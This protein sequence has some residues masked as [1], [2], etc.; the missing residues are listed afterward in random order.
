MPS[1]A[2]KVCE[3][4]DDG[5]HVVILGDL[6]SGAPGKG[7]EPLFGEVGAVD[8]LS[9]FS[10]GYTHQPNSGKVLLKVGWPSPIFG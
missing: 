3:H 8:R 10:M 6:S 2:T 1:L 9:W 4:F 7:Q 5:D